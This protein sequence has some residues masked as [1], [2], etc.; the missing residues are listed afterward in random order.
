MA[1]EHFLK[2]AKKS[3]KSKL[4]TILQ[5]MEGKRMTKEENKNY[6]ESFDKTINNTVNHKATKKTKK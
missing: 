4:L 1:I 5:S 3:E 6:F 2:V